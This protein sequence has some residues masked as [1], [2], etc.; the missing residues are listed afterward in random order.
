MMAWV[1]YIVPVQ[2][3]LTVFSEISHD[4]ARQSTPAAMEW[5][6]RKFGMVAITLEGGFQ[7][8]TTSPSNAPGSGQWDTTAP[9]TARFK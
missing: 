7:Q 4:P 3:G 5:I 1:V 6:S 8:T 9:G 2:V